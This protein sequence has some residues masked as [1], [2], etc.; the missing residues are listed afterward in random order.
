[1]KTMIHLHQTHH[2]VAD[3]AAIYKNTTDV[4]KGDGLH[5]FP[6]LYLTGYPLQDLVL[7]RA[8]IDSYIE[9]ENKLDEWAKKQT[10]NWR[11]LVGGLFYEIEGESLPKKIQNGIYEIVPGVGL[12]KLYAKRLLPNYDIFD[13]QKYFSPGKTNAFYDFNGE[14]Y[15]LQICEDMWASS[16]HEI[17]PCELM[18][19]E[20]LE[21]K[22][23]LK[24]IINLSASPFEA[25]KKSKRLERARNI[26]LLF[27]CPFIYLNRVG[28][29]DEILFDGTSF[30][31]NGIELVKELPS[32]KAAID[33]IDLS[34]IKGPYSEKPNLQQ[35][36]TWESLFSPR[37]NTSLNPA[38]L[39]SWS[40][41]ECLEV[42]Q[43]LQFGLQEYARK[44]GFKKFLIALSGGMDSALVLAITKLS[45]KPGQSV[46]A[47]Y[48]P[49]IHSAPLSTQLSEEMCRRLD[50][51]LSYLP[52]KFLHSTVKNTFTQ[53][54]AEPFIGLTDENVQ[55]RL[56]G[57][58]LYTRSNQTGAMV[59][60]TSNKSEI[61]VGYSTQYGDSVGAISLLGD[62][63]KTEV[64]G[65]A[66]FVNKHFNSPIPEGIID[67]GPSAELRANQ[68]DQDSLPPYS[69][70]DTILEGI[71][72]YRLGKPQ[73]MELGL[74]E[75]EIIKVLE[76]YSK[77]EYKRAQFC[78]ILKVKAKSFGFGYRVPISKSY[79]YQLE[80]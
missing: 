6:E 30:V 24:A 68:L 57:A 48:M 70:L 54:F 76:L 41:E 16:V 79:N 61:A 72:S 29:E 10:G 78:P 27:G 21:R 39:K 1:M 42:L 59:I 5:L 45:L 50:I 8:F 33:S 71:L 35:E 51:P 3:F 53:T 19:K 15:G 60:N 44:S 20:A 69:R 55:S 31:M 14:T 66:N 25:A 9:L 62:L 64:Y 75:K 46:E 2:T 67:R 73:L 49:S 52:I 56:R 58:L 26:S 38:V 40:E 65:L 23:N 43:A 36:N 17:D 34:Q 11:A 4:L 77:S 18:L 32:F 47:I 28:G 13:E 22:L 63:Y 74:P 37:I 12:K 7:Q 80:Y